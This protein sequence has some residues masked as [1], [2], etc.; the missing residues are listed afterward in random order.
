[1]LEQTGKAGE[2][3][4][5]PSACSLVPLFPHLQSALSTLEASLLACKEP[6]RQWRAPPPGSQS[7]SSGWW[8]DR[9]KG[10][11]FHPSLRYV[12]YRGPAPVGSRDSLGRTALA[13]KRIVKRR[14]TQRLDLTG[15]CG[16]LIKFVTTN[17][18]WPQRPQA[19]SR[20][21]EGAP[22]WALSRVGL[23]SPGK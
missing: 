21:A 9:C 20:I 22:P 1:M 3:A 4:L 19:P 17:L 10:L 11:V 23:R 13:I 18:L 8:L 2:H 12:L 7:V 14:K 6:P 16:K 15:L 5:S